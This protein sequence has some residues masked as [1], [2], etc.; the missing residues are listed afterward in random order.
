MDCDQ[1]TDHKRIRLDTVLRQKESHVNVT[2]YCKAIK[3]RQFR[4]SVSQMLSWTVSK[5]LNMST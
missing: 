4:L 1:R 5:W 2:R 3:R